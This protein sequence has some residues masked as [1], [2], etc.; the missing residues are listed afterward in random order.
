MKKIILALVLVL[1]SASG[2]YAGDIFKTFFAD[3][4]VGKEDTAVN[5][6]VVV[7]TCNF[8][9]GLPTGATRQCYGVLRNGDSTSDPV[10]LA[11]SATPTQPTISIN[12]V[13]LFGESGVLLKDGAYYDEV[14]G[15]A[16]LSIGFKQ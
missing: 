3:G 2:A 16:A 6:K 5:A 7:L 1:A 15:E 4:V 14:T 9:S 11:F 13:E 12:Y 10:L 8:Q